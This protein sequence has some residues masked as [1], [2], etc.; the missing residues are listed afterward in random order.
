MSLAP[1]RSLPFEICLGWGVQ[2]QPGKGPRMGQVWKKK[3]DNW[4]KVNKDPEELTYINDLTVCLPLSSSLGGTPIPFLF[5]CA[6]LPSILAK[7][8]I[9]LRVLLLLVVLYL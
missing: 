8:P 4:L 2:A 7:Q 1:P 3:P 6:S 9:S 5:G